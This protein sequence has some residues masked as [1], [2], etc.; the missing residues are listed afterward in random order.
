MNHP[1]RLALLIA[2]FVSCSTRSTFKKIVETGTTDPAITKFSTLD[3]ELPSFDLYGINIKKDPSIPVILLVGGSKCIP[4]FMYHEK[5]QRI[6]SSMMFYQTLIDSTYNA[7]VI[8]VEKRN[9]RS[10]GTFTPAILEKECSD[11]YGLIEKG[12]K[13]DDLI[14]VIGSLSSL[15][16]V[17]DIYLMGH[18]DGADI[19]S[20]AAHRL[21]DKKLNDHHVKAVA[22]LSS[23]GP[24]RT[25][26]RILGVKDSAELVQKEFD[27]LLWL[28]SHKNS[29]DSIVDG[30]PVKYQTSFTI[31]T[32]PL[33]ELRDLNIPVFIAHGMN[34]AKVNILSDDLLAAELLRNETRK[35]KYLRLKG[36]DHSYTDENGEPHQDLVLI[37]FMNW[38]KAGYPRE[39]ETK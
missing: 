21:G 12:D 14:S 22:F 37:S 36:L 35:V 25:F 23:G 8:G 29:G 3:G 10:F 18:S 17:G 20:G 34:D 1:A 38:I 2:L 28:T 27:K 19:V 7:N 39:V 26:E 11:T 5:K 24:T 15:D 31:D 6:V 16:R 4:L 9:I 30:D 33:D 13:V 32:T